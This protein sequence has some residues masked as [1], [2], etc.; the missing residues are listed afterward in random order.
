MSRF[1]AQKNYGTI[2][3]SVPH[4]EFAGLQFSPTELYNLSESITTNINTVIRSW[5][6]LEQALKSIGTEKDNQGLRDKV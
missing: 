5:K 2:D 1:D 6:T 4:V 3:N